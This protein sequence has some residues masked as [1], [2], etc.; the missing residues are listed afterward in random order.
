MAI[1]DTPS[2]DLMRQHATEAASLLKL[3]ANEDRL[4]L[5]C[6]L[7]QGEQNVGQ[8][9]AATGIHQPTLSQ[10]LGVLRQD[11]LV[12]TQKKGK[13]VYYSLASANVVRIMH[14][15]WEI[16]CAPDSNSNFGGDT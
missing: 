16:Y 5:L 10:Q 3:L 6:H 1:M 2:P 15:L 13:F 11:G 12:S 7:A 4:M 9:E 8:L 14:T